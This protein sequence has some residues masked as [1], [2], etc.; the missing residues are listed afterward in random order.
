LEEASVWDH[1][2]GKSPGSLN[3]GSLPVMLPL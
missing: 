2:G 1:C 3:A